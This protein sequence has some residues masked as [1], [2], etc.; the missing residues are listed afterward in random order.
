MTQATN[1]LVVL[2]SIFVKLSWRLEIS[3]L[4]IP[5]EINCLCNCFDMLYSYRFSHP[6]ELSQELNRLWAHQK[7]VMFVNVHKAQSWRKGP[8]TL[9]A[10]EYDA[11]CKARWCAQLESTLP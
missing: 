4:K 5:I 1:I 8:K 3:S 11:L 2:S 9:Q 10:G 7:H 6:K